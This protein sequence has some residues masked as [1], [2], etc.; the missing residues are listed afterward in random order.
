[1]VH[2]NLKEIMASCDV[3]DSSGEN[4]VVCK[5]V[6]FQASERYRS[7]VADAATVPQHDY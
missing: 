7:P 6:Q 1:M 4:E 2:R 3:M 5:I